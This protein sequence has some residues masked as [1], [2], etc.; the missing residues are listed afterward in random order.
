[1]KSNKTFVL[2]LLFL[3][4]LLGPIGQFFTFKFT[5]LYDL[6]LKTDLYNNAKWVQNKPKVFIMGSSHAKY[7]IIPSI[8]T[9]LNPQ[10]KPGDVVNVGENAASPFNMYTTYQK[11]K[12]KFSKAEIVYYTLEPHM[13]GEKYYLYNKYEKIFLNYDQWEYLEINSGIKNSYFYPFQTFIDS[14]L[15]STQDR[16]KTYGYSKLKH[17]KFNAFKANQVSKLIYEPI[18]LFPVSDFD[19]KYLKKLKEELNSNGTKFIF[20][21]TPTYSWAKHYASEAKTYDAMLI[22]KLNT[23]LG[24][25]PIIGSFYAEDFSLKYEDFKDDTHLADSGALKYTQ[26]LFK[27]IKQHK[28]LIKTPLKNTFLYRFTRNKQECIETNETIKPSN[29]KWNVDKNSYLTF[30][31]SQLE[32]NSKDIIKFAF[33]NS[34]FPP[35]T[36]VKTVTIQ[37][38]TNTNKIEMLSISLRNK[39]EFSHFFLK[40]NDFETGKI[41]LS[42]TTMNRTSKNFDFT[43]IDGLT[44]RVYPNTND[45]TKLIVKSINFSYCKNKT[46]Q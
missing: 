40:Q 7:T 21:L 3:F 10:L 6:N 33:I 4:I 8:I 16:S 24:P 2:T 29:F 30:N 42:Q 41:I 9:K 11:N 34:K 14:L 38:Q 32:L 18:E 22:D 37:I 39:N 25:T 45:I 46:K 5:P 26:L 23:N 43:N 13:W 1:M 35:R 36:D 12:D 15:F 17:K 28:N 20:V 19:M 44:I 31:N 27:N